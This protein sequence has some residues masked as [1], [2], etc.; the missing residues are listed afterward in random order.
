MSLVISDLTV[1]YGTVAALSGLDLTTEPGELFVL[2]GG[3]GSGKTTLLRA[4]AGFVR[5]TA[6]RIALEGVD[7]A[8]LPPHRRPVNTMFQSYALFPHLSVADNVAFGLRRQGMRGAALSA[9]VAEM[10]A[11]V[12]LS[13]LAGRRP[14]ELS[15][16]QQQRVA[17]A[18]SLAPGP[19]LLLLDE[20][21]SALDRGLR[22]ETRQELMRLQRRLGTSFILVTHDQDEALGMADRIGVMRDGRLAQVGAP[23]AVY[24]HPA[25]RFVAE[26]LGAANILAGDLASDGTFRLADGTILRTATVG[27]TGRRLLALRPE[28][29]HLGAAAN[30]LSGSVV[31]QDYGGESATTLVR[32][33]DGTLLRSV[34]ALDRGFGPARLA[35]GQDVTLGWSPDACIM[36]A[37]E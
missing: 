18:R 20:P 30:R 7:L 37:P 4:I 12:R 17:L 10:L 2:L 13:D 24:E 22:A 33:P 19:R 1:R 29:L 3:S 16:G 31:G 21:L 15:G 23:D 35:P 28:R 8:P 14:H 26:F 27:Q 36:L 34:Q 9:R 5:P 32:L 25:D 6:G 11:L